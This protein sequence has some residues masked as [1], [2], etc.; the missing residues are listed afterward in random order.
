MRR[1]T[2]LKVAQLQED[3]GTLTRELEG[4]KKQ[5]EEAKEVSRRVLSLLLDFVSLTR[6]LL[7]TPSQEVASLKNS[8]LTS[9]GPYAVS[10]SPSSP[11]PAAA[12][13]F[14]QPQSQPPTSFSSTLRLPFVRR[15]SLPSSHYLTFDPTI[16]PSDDPQSIRPLPSV[17]SAAPP[18]R[19]RPLPTP[20][21]SPPGPIPGQQQTFFDL[22]RL[23]PQ[24]A[25]FLRDALPPSPTG[26]PRSQQHQQSL[27][28]TTE[29]GSPTRRP[30]RPPAAPIEA[31]FLAL[32]DTISDVVR[33][34]DSLER[35]SDLMLT[36]EVSLV[37]SRLL[38]P[39]ASTS[40]EAFSSLFRIIRPFA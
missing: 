14:L 36:A 18:Q 1:E 19:M 32:V 34:M 11:S 38:V 40:T 4:T 6:F 37:V 9:L 35:K 7:D 29:E 17:L 31:N 16:P 26:S 3:V 23:P 21:Q 5:L 12:D 24:N 10:P 27:S 20:A 30:T 13:F 25:Q 22:H 39:L 15:R 33:A 8:L 28:S 2:D